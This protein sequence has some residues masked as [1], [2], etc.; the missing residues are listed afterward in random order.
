MQ[1]DKNSDGTLKYTPI[2]TEARNY[3]AY[4]NYGP[5]PYSEM[6]KWTQLQLNVGW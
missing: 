3:K 1:I 5:I 6:Q 2:D 4:M